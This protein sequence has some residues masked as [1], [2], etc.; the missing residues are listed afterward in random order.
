MNEPTTLTGYWSK[1]PVCGAVVW[2]QG[3]PGKVIDPALGT[4][5]FLENPP[6]AE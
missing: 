5:T 2:T 1:C 6:Y 4:G 3:E